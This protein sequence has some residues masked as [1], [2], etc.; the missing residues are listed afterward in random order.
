MSERNS[1]D[2]ASPTDVVV[3][4]GAREGDWIV[5]VR[6][7]IDVATSPRLKE[8][9]TAVLDQGAKF[10]TLDLSDL[11][12]IDS[13]G[14]GVLVGAHKRLLESGGETMTLRGLQEP[15]RR[16]FEITGLTKLFTVEE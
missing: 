6:G 8:H 10:V 9:L 11:G 16:V 3:D 2:A 15:V 1:T 7:E 14:L 13:S 4:R 12:F 5:R